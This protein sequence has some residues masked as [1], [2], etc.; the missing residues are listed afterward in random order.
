MILEVALRQLRDIVNTKHVCQLGH[1]L[2]W[3]IEMTS[4]WESLKRVEKHTCQCH[5]SKNEGCGTYLPTLINHLVRA[6]HKKA[7]A[8]RSSSMT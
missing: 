5:P 3:A 4:Y 2:L 7:V 8:G 6:E 1:L